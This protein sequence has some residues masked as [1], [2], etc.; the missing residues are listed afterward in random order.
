MRTLDDFSADGTFRQIMLRGHMLRL[1]ETGNRWTLTPFDKEGARCGEPLVVADF[2]ELRGWFERTPRQYTALSKL[3]KPV[4]RLERLLLESAW[5]APIPYQDEFKHLRLLKLSRAP[6]IGEALSVRKH[7]PFKRLGRKLLEPDEMR[8]D[9]AR[10]F[11]SP[12]YCRGN[13]HRYV[14]LCAP[15][16]PEACPAEA[17]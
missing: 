4:Q 1:D 5:V 7:L 10:T 13:I 11:R 3:P 17:P 16:T 2:D 8:A 12:F 15:F 14:V 9:L 6:G